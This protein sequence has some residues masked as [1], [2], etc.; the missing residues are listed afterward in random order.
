MGAF[1]PS[2][3]NQDSLCPPHK[4]RAFPAGGGTFFFQVEETHFQQKHAVIRFD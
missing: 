3:P 1:Q 2:Q 4:A